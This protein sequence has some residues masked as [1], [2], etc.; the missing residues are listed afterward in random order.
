[1]GAGVPLRSVHDDDDRPDGM[2]AGARRCHGF[3]GGWRDPATIGAPG[4]FH[5]NVHTIEDVADGLT[6]VH[7]YWCAGGF[8]RLEPLIVRHNDGQVAPVHVVAVES[9]ADEWRARTRPHLRSL[10]VEGRPESL[11]P[12]TCITAR[13]LQPVAE[14]P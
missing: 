5:L 12:G 13:T 8:D 3:C 10:L 14:L 2:G 7:G 1:M 9:P 11:E 4:G 6:R